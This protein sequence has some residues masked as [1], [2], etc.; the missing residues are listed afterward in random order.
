MMLAAA[1]GI[2]RWIVVGQTLSPLALACVEPL[3]GLTFALLH[4][5]AMRVIAEVVPPTLAASAQAT[6]G[7]LAA[8]AASALVTLASGPLF[9]RFA[10]EAFLAMAGLCVVALPLA[11]NLRRLPQTLAGGTPIPQNPG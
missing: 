9:D 5:S 6:Y 7:V 1:A 3:H 4:L 2:V 11:W 10:G 8:G